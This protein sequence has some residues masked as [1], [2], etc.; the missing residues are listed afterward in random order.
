M[1]LDMVLDMV[2]MMRYD[3]VFVYC[4]SLYMPYIQPT[5]PYI[6]RLSTLPK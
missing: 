1:V 2:L 4:T 6:I 5:I 3:A